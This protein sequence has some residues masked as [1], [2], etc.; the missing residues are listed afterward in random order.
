M[1][2][3]NIC[4]TC[5]NGWK[6]GLFH[7]LNGCAH[8]DTCVRP[9]ASRH[10]L[11]NSC[12]FSVTIAAF[13]V[14]DSTIWQWF[15]MLLQAFTKS[16]ITHMPKFYMSIFDNDWN[17]SKTA[18]FCLYRVRFSVLGYPAS[19]TFALF[20]AQWTHHKPD[21]GLPGGEVGTAA[22]RLLP[23]PLCFTQ[24]SVAEAIGRE[25]A[26]VASPE[27]RLCYCTDWF[28]RVRH[29]TLSPIS[30]QSI[31]VVFMLSGA[32][33]LRLKL[34]SAARMSINIVT[35]YCCHVCAVSMMLCR[36]DRRLCADIVSW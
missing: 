21:C 8:R 28:P 35:E 33:Y 32:I 15:W 20:L 3:C 26:Y 17:N 2:F 1:R 18:C 29:A 12:I 34:H 16:Y 14:L 27:Y 9:Q 7:I 5:K 31:C 24:R 6:R 4:E 22:F 36:S 13:P 19:F 25:P 30:S 11:W 23:R 10:G